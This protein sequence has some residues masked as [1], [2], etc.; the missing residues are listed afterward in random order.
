MNLHAPARP[1]G[2]APPRRRGSVRRTSTIDTSWPQ[3]RS[4][5]ALVQGHA[6]DLETDAD[7]STRVLAEDRYTIRSSADRRILEITTGPWRT[8]SGLVGVRGGGHLRAA[9]AEV[10]LMLVAG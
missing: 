7:G 6:R 8:V 4:E 2:P 3:G 9:L 10:P 5:P 1:I